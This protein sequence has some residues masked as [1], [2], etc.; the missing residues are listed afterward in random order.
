MPEHYIAP[1]VSST[2]NTLTNAT[3][4][5]PA[6]GKRLNQYTCCPWTLCLHTDLQGWEC[7]DL[8]NCGTAP[9]H[10]KNQHGITNMSR[11]VELVCVWQGCGC[12]VTRHN[13]VR[14]V[15]EHHLGHDRVSAH[16]SQPAL[17]PEGESCSHRGGEGNMTAV[18]SEGAGCDGAT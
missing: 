16:T 6:S 8:I 7:L 17:W 2:S 10:F 12:Q 9:D 5:A 14:H 15:R 18:E 4:E 11:E 13:Y 1:V 3:Q